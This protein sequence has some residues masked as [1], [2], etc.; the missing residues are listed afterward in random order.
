MSWYKFKRSWNIEN[1]F[2]HLHMQYFGFP[3]AVII[4]SFLLDCV[5]ERIVTPMNCQVVT[6]N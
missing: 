5:N 3:M 4:N 6:L 1:N 2:W